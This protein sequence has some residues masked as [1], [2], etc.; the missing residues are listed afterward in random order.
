M[1]VAGASIY[2]AKPLLRCVSRWLFWGVVIAACAIAF[3]PLRTLGVINDKL[4]HIV[5]FGLA[6]FLAAEGYPR[7]SPRVIL[8]MA[9]ACSV[10]VEAVQASPWV[11]RDVEFFDIVAGTA[12]A[13]AVFAIRVWIR[14]RRGPRPAPK[15]AKRRD[16]H[17]CGEC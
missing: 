8:V 6:T 11:G 17:N 9:V 3:S 10:A 12:G 5:A 1:A 7:V 14:H 15:S 4:D 2:S 16:P 13:A